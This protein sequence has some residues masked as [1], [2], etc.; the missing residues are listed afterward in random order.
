MRCHFLTC[1][2]E[3]ALGGAKS[4]QVPLVLKFLLLGKALCVLCEPAVG[5]MGCRGGGPQCVRRHRD[6]VVMARCKDEGVSCPV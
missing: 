2:F 3:V 6:D 5:V 4:G 1:L